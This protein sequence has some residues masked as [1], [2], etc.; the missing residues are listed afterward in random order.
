MDQ[1]RLTP[2]QAQEFIGPTWQVWL[3]LLIMI[4]GLAF[5]T[6]SFVMGSGG[7]P[8]A[9]YLA[10]SIIAFALALPVGFAGARKKSI[11]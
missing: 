8:V 10:G 5:L 7:V 11:D 1:P 9:K 4:I 3:M 6:A 2:S